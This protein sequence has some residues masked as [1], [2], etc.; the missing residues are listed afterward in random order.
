LT[1]AHHRSGV[2]GIVWFDWPASS[3]GSGGDHMPKPTPKTDDELFKELVEAVLRADDWN[4]WHQDSVAAVK[5][6]ASGNVFQLKGLTRIL[7]G[8]REWWPYPIDMKLVRQHGPKTIA[9][10]FLEKY[11][12]VAGKT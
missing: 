6:Q 11:A 5:W 9:R 7:N 8:D 3:F 4:R 12:K 10:D 1:R 2:D